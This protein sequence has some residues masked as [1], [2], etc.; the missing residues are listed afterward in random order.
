MTI[1]QSLQYNKSNNK[2]LT[3]TEMAGHTKT[4]SGNSQSPTFW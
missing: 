4:S 1:Q 2:M 3:F